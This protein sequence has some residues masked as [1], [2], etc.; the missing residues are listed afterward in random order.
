MIK[1]ITKDNLKRNKNQAAVNCLVIKSLS[2]KIEMV[3]QR[4]S[5]GFSYRYYKGQ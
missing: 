2:E 1:E 5:L 3:A 4:K